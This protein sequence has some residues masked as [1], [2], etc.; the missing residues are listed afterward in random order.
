MTYMTLEQPRTIDFGL[1]GS[2]RG[3]SSGV[4]VNDGRNIN[5]KDMNMKGVDMNSIILMLESVRRMWV[6]K[7]MLKMSILME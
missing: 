4:D 3:I 1:K 5:V 6:W 2:Y 7:Q